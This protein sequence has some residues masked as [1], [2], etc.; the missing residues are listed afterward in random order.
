VLQA[1]EA[2]I[3]TSRLHLTRAVRQTLENAL[4]LL[5]IATPEQM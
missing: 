1:P 3:R 4:R 2:S 5:V